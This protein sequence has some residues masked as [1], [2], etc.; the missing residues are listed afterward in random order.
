MEKLLTAFQDFFRMNFE[1]WVDGFDYREAGPQLLLQAFLQR[2]VNGGGRVEREYG[3]GRQRTDILVIWPY[4]TSI[5]YAVI[6]LKLLY[7]D[8]ETTIRAGVEQTLQ[9][10]DTCGASEGYLLI[11]N[12]TPKVSWQ[13]KIFKKTIPYHNTQVTVFGM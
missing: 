8:L 3:L 9:Y 10:M 5:Q 11:I 13:K 4:Q 12:K 1:S 6:E 7:G 2:I